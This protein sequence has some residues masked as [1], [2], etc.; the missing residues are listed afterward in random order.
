MIRNETLAEQ[1][2]Q[3]LPWPGLS[4]QYLL[5]TVPQTY[6]VGRHWKAAKRG[7]FRRS[8]DIPG[9]WIAE[10]VAEFAAAI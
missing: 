1:H 8:L 4:M 7:H 2:Y 3:I 9:V 6:S 5:D 10:E